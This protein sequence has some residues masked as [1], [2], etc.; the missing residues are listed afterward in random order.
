[1]KKKSFTNW[2]SARSYLFG[3]LGILA[4]AVAFILFVWPRNNKF[5]ALDVNTADI[6]T[7]SIPDSI[8]VLKGDTVVV[9]KDG[10]FVDGFLS[11][12]TVNRT[13]Q[14]LVVLEEL[15]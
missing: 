11:G 14:E 13:T 7:V 9:N 5:K 2:G 3:G 15:E 6:V 1:M 10:T 4:V 12:D 8:V